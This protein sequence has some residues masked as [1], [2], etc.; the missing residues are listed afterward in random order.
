M[1]YFN[2]EGDI[3]LI[4]LNIAL[5]IPPIEVSTRY[6]LNLVS[7]VIATTTTTNPFTL[8]PLL[9]LLTNKGKAENSYP[10]AYKEANTRKEAS[11][12][13]AKSLITYRHKYRSTLSNLARSRAPFI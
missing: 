1:S 2:L 12:K 8:G 11:T 6:S 4:K 9:A 5:V 13:K 7:R 10:T 3:P